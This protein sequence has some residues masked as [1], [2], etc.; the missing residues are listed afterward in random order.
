M[1]PY[2]CHAITSCVN[3]SSRIICAVSRYYSLSTYRACWSP[4]MG[5]TNQLAFDLLTLWYLSCLPLSSIS[6]SLVIFVNIVILVI[7]A[8]LFYFLLLLCFSYLP[9]PS[10]NRRKGAKREKPKKPSGFEIKIPWYIWPNSVPLIRISGFRW[11]PKLRHNKAL[12]SLFKKE[13]I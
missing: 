4:S 8:S 11:K 5:H 6:Y 1:P 10:C 13:A 12:I 2:F 9:C 7:F 3:Q